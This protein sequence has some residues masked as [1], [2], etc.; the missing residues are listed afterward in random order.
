MDDLSVAAAC[1]FISLATMFATF[2]YSN[3]IYLRTH[4]KLKELSARVDY[5]ASLSS[6]TA[7]V[8]K[9]AQAGLDTKITRSAMQSIT[10]QAKDLT[11]AVIDGS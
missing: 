2:Y 10:K 5:L 3:K 6:G 11:A 4:A 8:V 7:E 9:S 1:A